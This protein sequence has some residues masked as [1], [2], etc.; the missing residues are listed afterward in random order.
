MHIRAR[1]ANRDPTVQTFAGVHTVRANSLRNNGQLLPT[2]AGDSKASKKTVAGAH[3]KIK[4]TKKVPRVDVQQTTAHKTPP[5]KQE[6]RKPFYMN[7][8][9]NA[10]FGAFRCNGGTLTQV[11]QV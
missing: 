9:A 2:A 10:M 7:A 11:M 3:R 5:S 4:Q 6:Q 8:N 1:I